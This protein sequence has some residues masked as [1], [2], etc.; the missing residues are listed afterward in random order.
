M[1]T[2]PFRPLPSQPLGPEWKKIAYI[3]S[4][5]AEG[6]IGLA[7]FVLGTPAD[8]TGD[9]AWEI[10]KL[11]R[12]IH[13]MACTLVER[14]RPERAAETRNNAEQILGCFDGPIYVERLPNG[15]CSRPCC[16]HRPW[17]Q[18]TTRAGRIKI[19]WRK[20]VISIDYADTV[21][22]TKAEDLFADRGMTKF[23]FQVHASDPEDA[24]AVVQRILA[25]GDVVPA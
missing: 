12:P 10:Q 5:G 21:V 9:E 22:K 18:V 23:D 17:F 14:R 8:M 13:E 24:R 1:S 6:H 11:A 16:E 25:A 7:V 19:G 3:E 15:Y 2:E 4:V 20:R